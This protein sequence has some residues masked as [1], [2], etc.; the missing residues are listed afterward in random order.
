M[1]KPTVAFLGRPAESCSGKL[2]HFYAFPIP[3]CG[4]DVRDRADWDTWYIVGL[5]IDT[6]AGTTNQEISQ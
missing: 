5:L 2:Q 3:Y 4:Y 1:P 6:P